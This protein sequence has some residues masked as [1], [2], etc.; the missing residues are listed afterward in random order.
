MPLR[1][2][3]SLFV[4]IGGL[5]KKELHERELTAELESHLQLHIEDNLA[6]GHVSRQKPAAKH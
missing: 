3:R 1:Y 4:R 5:F 2:V 6:R